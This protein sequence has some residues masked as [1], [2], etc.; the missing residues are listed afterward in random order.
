[1]LCFK[2]NITDA[3]ARLNNFFILNFHFFRFTHEFSDHLFF[4]VDRLPRD[5]SVELAFNHFSHTNFRVWHP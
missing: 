2:V 5:E 1:L 4:K 3:S